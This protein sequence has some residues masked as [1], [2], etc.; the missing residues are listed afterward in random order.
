MLIPNESEIAARAIKVVPK[1]WG[2][3]YWLVN[4]PKYCWK[5]LKINPGYVSSVHSH[6]KKNETFYGVMGTVR[7]DIHDTMTETFAPIIISPGYQ[8]EI[9]RGTMHSFRSVNTAW[10]SEISTHHD[11]NDVIRLQPSRKLEP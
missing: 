11:D 6:A 7:L 3:E 9:R 10:I 5:L 8:F 1:L 2:V 4:T